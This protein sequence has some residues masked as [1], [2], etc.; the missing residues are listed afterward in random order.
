MRGISATKFF[1]A[2]SQ[3]FVRY[4]SIYI[5]I[6]VCGKKPETKV[7]FLHRIMVLTISLFLV[8]RYIVHTFDDDL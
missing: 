5:K 4:S 8:N 7:L 2:E 3:S 1:F 6:N